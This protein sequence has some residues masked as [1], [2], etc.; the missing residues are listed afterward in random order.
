VALT[1][2]RV[3]VSATAVALNTEVGAV[4]GT[5]LLIKNRHATDSVDLGGSGVTAGAGYE[6]KPADPPLELFLPHGEQIYA[7]RSAAADVVVHVI[8]LGS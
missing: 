7:I 3:T 1:S 8:R 2:E 6:L 5:R 4:S